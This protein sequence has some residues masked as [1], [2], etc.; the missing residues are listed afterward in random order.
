MQ[1]KIAFDLLRASRYLLSNGAIYSSD[2]E[3][4]LIDLYK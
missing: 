4:F 3:A 2:H 1:L